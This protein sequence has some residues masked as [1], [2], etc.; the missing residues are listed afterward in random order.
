VTA[1]AKAW[2]GSRCADFSKWERH[3]AK[4][5]N[6]DRIPIASQRS[7][8]KCFAVA[9]DGQCS[10]ERQTDAAG[11]GR[12]ALQQPHVGRNSEE[13]VPAGEPPLPST[14]GRL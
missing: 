7:L 12:Q 5:T 2:V 10:S 3:G 13:G 1:V 11:A 9:Y 8:D 6:W 14:D 4:V